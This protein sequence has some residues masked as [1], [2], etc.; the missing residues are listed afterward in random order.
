MQV[1]TRW[2]NKLVGFAG[3]L[4]L[5]VV[6]HNSEAQAPLTLDEA[7]ALATDNYP[8]ARQRE[9]TRQTEA[10][11]KEN[12]RSSF[13]PQVS[14]LGQGSYQSDVTRVAIPIQG[15]KVPEQEKAQYRVY[16]D[17]SQQLYDG[18]LVREQKAVQGLNTKV[19]DSRVD[20]ELHNV[21]T[22]VTNLFFGILYQ[23]QLLAQSDLL[24]TDIKIGINKVR[25]QVENG[26]VLRSSLLVLEAQKLQT[27]QRII[28]IRNTKKGFLNALATLLKINLS[29]NATLEMPVIEMPEDTT[30]ARPE[31]RLY[32]S[33][34]DLLQGQKKLVDA[35][36][37][38]KLT[39]F[40]QPGYGRPG[41]NLFSTEFD[42]FY[43]TGIRLNWSLSGLYN[44]KRDK[45][46]LDVSQRSINLQKE[47]FV[48]NTQSQLSQQSADIQKFGE[49]I[50]A[51]ER[52]IEVR[53]Q[54]TEAAKAQLENAVI[55]A[56]DYL[57]E[58]SGEDQARQ[59]LII[60]RLQ[61][62]QAKATYAITAGKL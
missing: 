37:K 55:T 10:L 13:L 8:A 34:I 40:L 3:L 26:T 6:T 19:E 11:T 29:E 61:L 2:L 32:Q 50:T 35:R 20:V 51:D 39:A 33:Q 7:F 16:A 42:A 43:T 62:L 24:L 9:L 56:N 5:L 4:S 15:I 18:G 17:V 23:Q 25:P 53:H 31:L 59:N 52:I 38:P 54:I 27:E 41:L 58:V 60:H 44:F 49:L 57:R 28:E 1:L 47:T 30:V 36:N 45:Q 14:I 12:L 22:R 48:L 21:K 46:L